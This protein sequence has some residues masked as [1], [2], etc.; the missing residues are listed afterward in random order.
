MKIANADGYDCSSENKYAEISRKLRYS[1]CL[2][3][4]DRVKDSL[5]LQPSSLSQKRLRFWKQIE[6]YHYDRALKSEAKKW[7]STDGEPVK[8]RCKSVSKMVK[9][10]VLVLQATTADSPQNSNTKKSTRRR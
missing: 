5:S 2:M 8:N 9:N 4:F 7:P 3:L 6:L 10:L 1:F